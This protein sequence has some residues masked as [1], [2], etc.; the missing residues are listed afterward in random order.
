M[1]LFIILATATLLIAATQA[2][3]LRD[4][5]FD[6]GETQMSSKCTRQVKM[7]EPELVKCNR[8][9]AMDIMDDK[10]EEALSRIQGE[11]CE[12]EEKFL[13]GCCVAMKEME[14]ECVCEWMKM[15]VENQKGR[16]GETLMRKGIRDLKE[17]PNKCGISEMECHSRGNWYY[18]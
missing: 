8:Y 12:S 13:R 18:V 16:I 4:E 10:Y 15:M 2:K 1:K 7:M 6:L 3:Y 17:L 11:G 5:G 9:I 14:D